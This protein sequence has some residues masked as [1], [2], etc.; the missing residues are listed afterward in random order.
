M[1][2]LEIAGIIF[3]GGLFVAAILIL[4]KTQRPPVIIQENKIVDEVRYID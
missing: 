4:V 2:D 3:Y 1:S